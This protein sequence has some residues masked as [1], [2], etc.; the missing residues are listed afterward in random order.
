[1]LSYLWFALGIAF[2]CITTNFWALVISRGIVGLG[3]AGM[4]FLVTIIFNDII[5]LRKRALWQGALQWVVFAGQM[6][7]GPLGGWFVDKIG[8]RLS[9]FLELPMAL[10]AF[11]VVLHTLKLPKLPTQR[12]ASKPRPSTPADQDGTFE[13]SNN[14]DILGSC[15]LLAC[16]STLVLGLGMAGNDVSWN[17]PSVITLLLASFVLLAAFTYVELR[18]ALIPLIPLEVFK[19]RAIWSVFLTTF[20]KDFA[21]TAVIYLVPL[22]IKFSGIGD[23]STA[24]FYLSLVFLGLALGQLMA[25]LLID[26]FGRPWFVLIVPGALNVAVILLVQQRWTGTESTGER[27]SEVLING[28]LSGIVGCTLLISL[29]KS[30][31]KTTQATLYG[32]YHVVLMASNILC[33]AVISSMIQYRSIAH[34]DANLSGRYAGDIPKLVTSCRRSLSCLDNLPADIEILV[35]E[36]F[37]EAVQDSLGFTTIVAGVSFVFSLLTDRFHIKPRGERA[38]TEESSN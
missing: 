29:L 28:T 2:C 21:G 16:I 34:L 24:G 1:M 9:F 27:I 35:R 11:G 14:F 15:V 22:H 20:C 23:T 17:H 30:C 18:V 6:T 32:A 19:R 36:S 31:S 8:W 10:I 7:G 4:G 38:Y 37:N 5:S 12:I 26:L 33:V 13:S 25:G 3:A